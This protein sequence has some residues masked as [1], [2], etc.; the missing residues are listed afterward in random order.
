MSRPDPGALPAAPG[1]YALEIRLARTLE[2]PVAVGAS[3]EA[4]F[5]I[6]REVWQLALVKSGKHRYRL[7][8][9]SGG[10]VTETNENNNALEGVLEVIN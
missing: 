7:V 2:V 6:P 3:G 9:D 5:A 10:R 4:R 1:A 8:V